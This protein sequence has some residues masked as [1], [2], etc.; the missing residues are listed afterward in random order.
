[1]LRVVSGGLDRLPAG[2]AAGPI[3]RGRVLILIAAVLAAGLVYVNVGALE[4]GD[5]FGRSS[6]RATELQRE[7]TQLRAKIA[8]LGSTDRIQKRAAKLGLQMP[9]P[10]QFAFVRAD[11]GDPLRATRT[12]TAPR[13]TPPPSGGP[14]TTTGPAPAANTGP[15][16]ALGTPVGAGAPATGANPAAGGD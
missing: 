8:Q 4:A 2:E 10:E 1:M 7:N 13:P 14:S 12:Y 6:L 5:S 15:S 11:D 9:V 3:A 16:A